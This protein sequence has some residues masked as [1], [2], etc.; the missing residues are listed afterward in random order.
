VVR[1][2]DLSGTPDFESSLTGKPLQQA[3]VVLF[4]VGYAV[5]PYFSSVFASPRIKDGN[6][7][8]L[9][10]KKRLFGQ[11][12]QEFCGISVMHI[13]TNKPMG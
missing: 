12:S 3:L 6:V 13:H 10:V 1:H 5:C 8:I 7:H 4:L 9:A 2:I 11:I